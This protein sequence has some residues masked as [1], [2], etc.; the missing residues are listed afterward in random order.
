MAW[1]R[2]GC[3][4]ERALELLPLVS[5]FSYSLQLTEF[6]HNDSLRSLLQR[7][8]R[9]SLQSYFRSVIEIISKGIV[10]YSYLLTFFQSMLTNAGYDPVVGPGSTCN[11]DDSAGQCVIPWGN[12]TKAVSSVVLIANSICFLAR[13]SLISSCPV[14]IDKSTIDHDD[15]IHL[16]QRSSRLRQSWTLAASCRHYHQLD[17]IICL[18]DIDK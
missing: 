6:S 18:H 14:Y 11:T 12:G 3:Y 8:Q 16:H 4:S 1:P 13:L 2:G 15:Y 7:K 5:H 9:V 10:P 17:L